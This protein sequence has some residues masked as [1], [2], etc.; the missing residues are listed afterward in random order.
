MIANTLINEIMSECRIGNKAKVEVL[1]AE[2][3]EYIDAIETELHELHSYV[4]GVT[5]LAQAVAT[6]D[7]H[8]KLI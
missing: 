4:Q 5:E 6:H 2:L 3:E 7:V 1:V 8:G